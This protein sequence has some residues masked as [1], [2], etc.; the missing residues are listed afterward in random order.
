MTAPEGRYVVYVD[1]R[2]YGPGKGRKER[3]GAVKQASAL[4]SRYV[5]VQVRFRPDDGSR[6]D[7]VATWRDG[8]Q[9]Q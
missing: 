6:G 5:H 1:G 4:A 8:Y 7:P 3:S 9:I 2:V